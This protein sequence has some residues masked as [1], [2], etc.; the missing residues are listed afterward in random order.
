MFKLLLSLLA[1]AAFLILNCAPKPKILP[2]ERTPQ[3]VLECA[4]R[5]HIEF[6]TFACIMNL[7]LKGEKTKF[8]STV[9]FF[10]QSPDLYSFYP[11]SLWGGNAF[12]AI[13]EGD[14]L[15]FY[16]S[17]DNEYYAGN[18][19]DFEKSARWGLEIDLQTLLKIITGE[20][21]LS[22]EDMLYRGQDKKSFIYET[23]DERWIKQ[24]WI[25]F[26]KCRLIKS[27]WTD[28]KWDEVYQI[29]Y[30]NFAGF[31]DVELARTIKVESSGNESAQIK[32]V[33]RK[34]DFPIPEKK[35]QLKIPPDA[36]RVVFE[37]KQK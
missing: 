30:K 29:E 7:K 28:K 37:P 5:N 33:E 1:L 16:F 11:R 20:E 19:S 14:S 4:A 18:F 24:H 21:G 27:I 22:E 32:F 3:K 12:K 17:N 23:E 6:D 8:S 34:F 35:F 25:D 36:T 10:Y 2:E 13:G 15:T 31:E 9:E 26:N